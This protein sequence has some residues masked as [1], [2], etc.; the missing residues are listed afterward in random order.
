[1]LQNEIRKRQQLITIEE[2]L[3]IR[4]SLSKG[5]HEDVLRTEK[6]KSTEKSISK[7]SF[8]RSKPLFSKNSI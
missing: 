8:H 2:A 3:K 5:S 4:K 6:R 7:G 1:M